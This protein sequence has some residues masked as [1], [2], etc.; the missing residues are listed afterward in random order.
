ML[1]EPGMPPMVSMKPKERLATGSGH[2]ILIQR[3][4][5]Q[6]LKLTLLSLLVWKV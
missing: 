6:Y 5:F 1:I 4:S 2:M 3:I